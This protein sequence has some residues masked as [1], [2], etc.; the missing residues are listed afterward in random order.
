MKVLV[1]EFWFMINSTDSIH[2]NNDRDNLVNH[3]ATFTYQLG[4]GHTT[5]VA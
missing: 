4:Q 3:S 1:T 2:S 5:C